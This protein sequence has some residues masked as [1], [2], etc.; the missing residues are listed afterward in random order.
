MANYIDK[1]T[2]SGSTYLLHDTELRNQLE[3]G[4]IYKGVIKTETTLAMTQNRG[5]LYKIGANGWF[6]TGSGKYEPGDT[7]PST[8][9]S[10]M[11]VWVGDAL[12]GRCF[13][14][15]TDTPGYD[16][17][18]S[19]DNPHTHEIPL[20]TVTSGTAGAHSHSVTAAGDISTIASHSHAFDGTEGTTSAAT[21]HSHSV[22]IP[23]QTITPTAATTG[24][25]SGATG[26]LSGT[27]AS[28]SHTFNG[29]EASH[30][31]TFSGTAASH[32]HTFNGT[33]TN[34]SQVAS[35]TH[36]VSGSIPGWNITASTYTASD[37]NAFVL[38][39]TA[40]SKTLSG[41]VADAA[42]AHSHTVT[43]TGT[44]GV[45]T[46]TPAGTVGYTSITPAGSIG[47]VTLTPAGTISVTLPS[48]GA[49]AAG[50]QVSVA[51]GTYSTTQAGGHSHTFTPEG[52]VGLGGAHSH[53]FTGTAVST[54][55]VAGHAHEVTIPT[56]NTDQAS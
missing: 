8:D 31:H 17:L 20:M 26:S 56:H 30:N 34:T 42:G 51:G 2:L 40:E 39:I 41:V 38:N 9:P 14:T 45:T 5:W 4:V 10:W 15:A 6:N 48:F 22:T 50:M 25:P 29:T 16:Y 46:I 49:F 7:K 13:S 55:Q 35:H 53:T 32:S 18:P 24:A 19:A 11:R 43:A 52:S 36:N 12:I 27:A 54:S 33:Q 37:V 28:H 21:S 44:I 3:S 1:I 23:A 47:V